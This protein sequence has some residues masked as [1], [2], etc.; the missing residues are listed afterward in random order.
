MLP[1]RC[2]RARAR[3]RKERVRALTLN[4]VRNSLESAALMYLRR[5]EEGAVKY[6]FLCFL[7]LE[8]TAVLNF[9]A[10]RSRIHALWARNRPAL[11]FPR[12]R[13]NNFSAFWRAEF[14]LDPDGDALFPVSTRA[15]RQRRRV[16]RF[17]ALVE[18]FGSLSA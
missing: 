17:C 13:Q 8:L 10:P 11:N 16:R 1:R 6:A 2:A 14:F 18:G 12:G 9:M 4:L 15:S 3:A 7:R 5:C